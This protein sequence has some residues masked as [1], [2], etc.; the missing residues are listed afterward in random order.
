M[1]GLLILI[2]VAIGTGWAAT[3]IWD[4]PEW[5]RQLLL[6]ITGLNLLAVGAFLTR[7]TSARRLGMVLLVAQVVL[8]ATVLSAAAAIIILD[9]PAAAEAPPM[10]FVVLFLLPVVLDIA[11][12]ALAARSIRRLESPDH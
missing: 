7:R 12:T 1:I 9:N 5:P 10:F 6:V 8:V 4:F 2:A 11:L 3:Q